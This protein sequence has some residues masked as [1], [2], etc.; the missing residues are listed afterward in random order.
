MTAADTWARQ[1]GKDRGG[2]RGFTSIAWMG[3]RE[4]ILRRGRLG[5]VTF[6]RTPAYSRHVEPGRPSTVPPGAL[7]RS[8][9]TLR[10][11]SPEG[12]LLIVVLSHQARAPVRGLPGYL[13]VLDAHRRRTR[14]AGTPAASSSSSLNL[15]VR[16]GRGMQ[17]TGLRVGV[18]NNGCQ[19][20]PCHEPGSRF[21]SHT[22]GNPPPGAPFPNTSNLIFKNAIF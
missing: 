12:L 4:G 1:F 7:F 22:P 6:L 20:Q 21:V 9:E 15:P 14:S 13:R 8:E 2:L 10:R 19:L 18:N 5:R 17:N 11:S 16:G 3:G